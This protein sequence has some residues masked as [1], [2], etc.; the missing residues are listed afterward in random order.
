AGFHFPG[1]LSGDI[2]PADVQKCLSRFTRYGIDLVQFAIA[3]P[4]C[5][6]DPDPV[7]RQMVID[8]ISRASQV[9][10]DLSAH[11]CLLRPGSL[12][13]AGSW[14]PHR[15][16]HTPRAWDQLLAS[17]RSLM[18]A[19]EK[20][21]VMAVMETHLVSILR[22]PEACRE[23]VNT[24]GSPNL[25]LVMDYVNHF[26]TLQ[27]VYNNRERLDHIFKEMGPYAPVLHIKDIAIGKGLVLHIEETLPGNGELDLAYCFQKFQGVYP[28]GY[29]LIE[30][31]PLERIPE[32]T[33]NTRAIASR[34]GVL[35]P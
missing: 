11:C 31:L 19:L 13:H 33:K 29:G 6:F 22:N 1:H 20:N 28:D 30:H 24:I 15:D 17:L 34:V 27:H 8:K 2:S 14:T 5:L 26:E 4:E 10:A 16:N 23:M 12:S 18:P 25:R 35:K 3:Y 7:A 32:A 21:G 9:A